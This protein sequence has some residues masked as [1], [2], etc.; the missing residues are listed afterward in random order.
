MG[1]G[2][3]ESLAGVIPQGSFWL[4]FIQFS[5]FPSEKMKIC[6]EEKE[7]LHEQFHHSNS[8]V[9]GGLLVRS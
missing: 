5:S 7:V 2:N 4:L 3:E 8:T 6:G 9:P 1:E